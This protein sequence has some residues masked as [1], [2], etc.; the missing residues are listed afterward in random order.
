MAPIA[1]TDPV[2]LLGMLA[3]LAFLAGSVT[4]LYVQISI[5]NSAE[6]AINAQTQLAAVSRVDDSLQNVDNGDGNGGN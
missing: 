6:T 5:K 2:A 4:H 1:P 3:V